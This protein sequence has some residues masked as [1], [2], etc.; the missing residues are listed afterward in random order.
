MARPCEL[1]VTRKTAT[2]RLVDLGADEGQ[3]RTVALAIKGEGSCCTRSWAGLPVVVLAA[4]A[5]SI[6]GLRQTRSPSTTW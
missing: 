3:K 5:M 2:S 1:A 6:E 4:G